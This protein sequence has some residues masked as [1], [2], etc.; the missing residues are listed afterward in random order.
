MK[1]Q[2][3]PLLPA[4]MDMATKVALSKWMRETAI[5][6]NALQ[7]N[8]SS[9]SLV[10]TLVETGE[11]FTVAENYQALYNEPITVDGTLYVDGMLIYV[12]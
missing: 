11:S 9:G 6:I 3:T 7:D 4:S 10:P 1:V 5:I 12:D 8:A 2:E